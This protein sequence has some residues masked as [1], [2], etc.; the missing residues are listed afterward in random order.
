ME[1]FYAVTPKVASQGKS[2]TTIDIES[3][4]NRLLKACYVPTTSA[5]LPR[6]FLFAAAINCTNKANKAGGANH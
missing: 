3:L 6:L 1:Y 4:Q 5:G 2:S